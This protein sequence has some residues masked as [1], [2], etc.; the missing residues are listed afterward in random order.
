MFYP[1]RHDLGWSDV[2]RGG[3]DVILVRG[4]HFSVMK[5]P[6]V[7]TIADHLERCLADADDDHAVP[8]VVPG[9]ANIQSGMMESPVV[10]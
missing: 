6:L 5:A 7:K 9:S 8:G 1:L 10:A 4:D 3:V 2:A